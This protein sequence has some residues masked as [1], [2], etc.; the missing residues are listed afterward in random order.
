MTQDELMQICLSL[1]DS[2]GHDT[3]YTEDSLML[4]SM[5]SPTYDTLD[6]LRC[7]PVLALALALK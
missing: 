4:K 2:L 7:N 3:S 5:L 1:V 6:S